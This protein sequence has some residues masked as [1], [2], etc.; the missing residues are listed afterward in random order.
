MGPPAGDV[1]VLLK[2]NLDDLFDKFWAAYPKKVGKIKVKA[3]VISLKPT[4][5]LVA[6]MIKKIEEYK[7]T[8]QW[9]TEKGRYIPNPLTW[10]NRGSWEDDLTVQ[11]LPPRS[12]RRGRHNA[13][14]SED[15]Y[16]LR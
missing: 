5:E 11:T 3:K 15:D 14:I 1:S 10:L 12:N 2:N 13:D 16:N 6:V 9:R 4:P 8:D 7:L